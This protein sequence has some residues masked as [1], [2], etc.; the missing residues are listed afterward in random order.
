M[1]ARAAGLAWYEKTNLWGR[2]GKDK[3]GRVI[4]PGTPRT[5]ELPLGLP[6]VGDRYELPEVFRYLDRATTANH[7]LE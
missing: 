5:T 6:V 4:K 2:I 3:N 7:K 1:Q